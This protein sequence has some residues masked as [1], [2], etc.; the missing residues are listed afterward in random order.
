MLQSTDVEQGSDFQRV[1]RR[2]FGKGS[3]AVNAFIKFGTHHTA[4]LHDEYQHGFYLCIH[5]L[6]CYTRDPRLNGSTY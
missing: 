1:E 2:V 6:V 4:H 5:R 3:K